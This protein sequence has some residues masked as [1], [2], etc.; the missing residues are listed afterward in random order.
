MGKLIAAF[1]IV[2]FSKKSL[3]LKHPFFLEDQLQKLEH[4]LKFAILIYI[5]SWF[6]ATIPQT[7]PQN[8][9]QLIHKSRNYLDQKCGNA[10]I[11]AISRHLWYLTEELVPLS[12]FS[13]NVDG[14]TKSKI[15]TRMLNSKKKDKL[16]NLQVL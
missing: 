4:F 7:A 2:M 6:T 5:P 11:N 10:A 16:S 1:K 9:L 12:L 14:A 13:S 3:V 8:D 15:A